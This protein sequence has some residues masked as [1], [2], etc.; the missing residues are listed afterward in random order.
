LQL[1]KTDDPKKLIVTF[2][3]DTEKREVRASSSNGTTDIVIRLSEDI[4]E[5]GTKVMQTLLDRHVAFALANQSYAQALSGGYVAKHST[6]PLSL[7]PLPNEV[8]ACTSVPKLIEWVVD[9][10]GEF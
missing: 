9:V 5:H 2:T 8:V 3:L 10:I 6:C 7:P 1:E 4:R